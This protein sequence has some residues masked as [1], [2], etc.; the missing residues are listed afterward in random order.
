M[1]AW[2]GKTEPFKFSWDDLVRQGSTFWD[3][4]RNAQ[5]RNNLQAMVVG[6]EFFLYHSNE[7]L[8]VVGLARVIGAARRDP[9][10]E[11][12]DDR[13]LGVDIAPVAALPRPVSL[14]EIKADPALVGMAFVRQ[15]RLSVSPVTEAERDR[16]LTLG[17]LSLPLVAR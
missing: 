10:A 7:G 1:A 3:G 17:G 15:G 5:A 12:G 13:W 2:L 11:E 8:A 9:S 4:V 6:D 16:I 14:K